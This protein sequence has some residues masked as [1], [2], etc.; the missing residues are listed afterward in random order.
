MQSTRSTKQTKSYPYL[1]KYSHYT[2]FLTTKLKMPV[3]NVYNLK[4]T[5]MIRQVMIAKLQYIFSCI[6]QL[7]DKT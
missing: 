1:V 5:D 6:L 7:L 2:S 4:P 3:H